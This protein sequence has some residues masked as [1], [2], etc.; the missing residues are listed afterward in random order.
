[1]RNE[2]WR[3]QRSL[4]G[5]VS[6]HLFGVLRFH[7]ARKGAKDGRFIVRT[8]G[9][10]SHLIV[11]IRPHPLCFRPT[12]LAQTGTRSAA[13]H[14]QYALKMNCL[15]VEQGWNVHIARPT[16]EEPL[17]DGYVILQVEVQFIAIF[18]REIFS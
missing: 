18:G 17:A 7:P 15:K 9:A 12:G 5:C 10:E 8:S 13:F 1:M 2:E 4:P 3:V 6:E 11:P 14:Q 16:V